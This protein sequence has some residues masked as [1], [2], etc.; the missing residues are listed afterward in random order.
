MK[1]IYQTIKNKNKW[2]LF[3][4][5][6]IFL[7]FFLFFKIFKNIQSDRNNKRNLSFA[8]NFFSVYKTDIVSSIEK[9]YK[10]EKNLEFTKSYSIILSI[11]DKKIEK[12]FQNM[13]Y[14]KLIRIGM[15]TNKVE[16]LSKI[17]KKIKNSKW[18]GIAENVF[19]DIQKNIFSNEN[20]AKFF[21]KNSLKKEIPKEMK[22]IIQIKINNTIQ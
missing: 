20:N 3:F 6:S 4:F 22:E 13:M 18:I 5:L 15:Q 14:I 1:K 11:L 10:F 21:Y 9:S 8:K 12:D 2:I 7:V 19:G 17:F 16:D